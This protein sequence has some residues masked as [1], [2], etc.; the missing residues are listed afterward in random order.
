VKNIKT[1]SSWPVPLSTYAA[2]LKFDTNIWNV[3]AKSHMILL[4]DPS[5]HQCFSSTATK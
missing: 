1:L 4:H 5:P 2:I 3:R